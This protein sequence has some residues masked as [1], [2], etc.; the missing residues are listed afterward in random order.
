M[1]DRVFRVGMAGRAPFGG[2]EALK[3]RGG[4]G[5]VVVVMVMDFMGI[6]RC[7]WRMSVRTFI[8]TAGMKG[9]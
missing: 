4:R 1:E 9:W 2:C 3:A 5:N 8:S 7:S 6:L